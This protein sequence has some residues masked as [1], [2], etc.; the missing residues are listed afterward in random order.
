MQ[1]MKLELHVREKSSVQHNFRRDAGALR[2]LVQWS[3]T[4]L[5][6]HVENRTEGQ[7][8]HLSTYVCSE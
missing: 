7:I 3:T 2:N 8:F 4:V 6:L 5:K 1:A